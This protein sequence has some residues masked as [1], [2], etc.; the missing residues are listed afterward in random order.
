M[1]SDKTKKI[2]AVVIVAGSILFSSFFF[3]FY[4]M[5]KSP[6]ILVEKSDGILLIAPNAS[7]RSVQDSL[8]KYDIAHNL[9][10][11]SF[12]AKVM[13]Y[14]AQ[15]KP[16][17]YLLKANMNNLDAIRLL[18]SGV[19]APINL[20]FNTIRTK[21]DLA[22]KITTP[23]A[24]SQE[25]FLQ[26]LEDESVAKSY[27]FTSESIMAMFIPNT[28]QVYWTI[29]AKD[30]FER[31]HTEYKAFWNEERKQKAEA[32]G[33]SPVEVSIL[34][35]IVQAES[36]K[37]DES[38]VIAGVYLNRLKRGIPLQA[39]PTLVFAAGD[40]TIQRVLNKHKE[41][42]SPYNTYKFAGL[43]PGPINLPDIRSIDAVLNYQS[44]KYLYF[45]AKDD[46]SGYHTFATNLIDHMK[47]AQRY[48]DALNKAKLYK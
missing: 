10:A 29:S 19:Q 26:L 46:F 39:D 11:F 33:L 27:G 18:R 3:Y 47:N 34:A 7:F 5:V 40:F 14:D 28:Y 2:L 23:L 38:P 35:S 43:P 30:L 9:V 8:I 1:L 17:R 31:M 22:A 32:I 24:I 44:H 36:S 21:T 20:T 41:I 15:I 37:Y 42:N 12:L 6:N 48:Q 4:Q 45:C 25:E 16:G 13:D